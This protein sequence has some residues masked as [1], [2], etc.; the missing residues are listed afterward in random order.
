MRGYI[1]NKISIAEKLDKIRDNREKSV[2]LSDGDWNEI[3]LF[4]NSVD[5]DF[6]TR[7]KEKNPELSEDD[8]NFMVLLRLRMP[9]KAMALIYGIS[10]KSIRQKLFVYK[11]KVGIEDKKDLSLRTFI[12]RF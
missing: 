6:V 5:C 1:L 9:S 4:V 3:R 7:L 8:I 10:E 12:E 11:R 2:P